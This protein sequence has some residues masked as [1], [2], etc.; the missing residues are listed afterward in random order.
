M[1][2]PSPAA[3]G[4]WR[5]LAENVAGN[6]IWNVIRIIA[7]SLIVGGAGA[8]L[9][10]APLAEGLYA[11]AVLF[12]V[13]LLGSGAYLSVRR[14]KQGTDVSPKTPAET[15]PPQKLTLRILDAIAGGES[16]YIGN[17][18]DV[19]IYLRVRVVNRAEPAV[20]VA[21]WE[22]DL[23]HGEEH[24]KTAFAQNLVTGPE[25][26]RLRRG[27]G[28]TNNESVGRAFEK[29]PIDAGASPEGWIKFDVEGVLLHYIFGATFVL[30]A[31]DDL[32]NTSSCKMAP[33]EWLA[34]VQLN[35]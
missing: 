19:G 13:Y 21:T 4:P 2:K 9:L 29:K 5:R 6:V 18:G 34:P 30:R 14:L 11:S 20:T 1:E 16:V 28:E 8:K 10:K 22:L 15:E 12:G 27:T 17:Q 24:W 23:F 35:P 32:E 3:P 25:F 33:G 7:G 31:V 26:R